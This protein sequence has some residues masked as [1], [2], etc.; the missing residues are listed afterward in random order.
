MADTL[1]QFWQ[2]QLAV[3]QADQKAAQADL[4][5]AQASLQSARA[6]L[7]TDQKALDKAGSD[8]A[9][10]RAQLAVTTVPA[11]ANALVAQITQ[12]IIGQRALQG[13]V[14]DDKDLFADIQASLDAATATLARATSRVT[15]IQA[16]I[17]AAQGDAAKRDIYRSAIVAAPLVTLKGDATAFLASA[18]VTHAKS[19]IGK[20]FPG[21][22]LAIADK[23]HDTRTNR[24]KSLQTDLSNACDALAAEQATDDGLAGA[25]AQ[26]KHAFQRAQDTL[27]NYVAV[28]A[29][30]FVK[31]KAVMAALEA[32]EVAPPNTVSDVLTGPEQAQL[33]ALLP[34]GEA[35]EPTAENL[36]TDLNGVF[37]ADAALKSQILAAI[38]AN[39]DG[40]STDPNINAKRTAVA[41]AQTTF[42]N[43]LAAFAAANKKDLDLWEAVVPDS[44][45][46][47]LVDYQEALAALNDLSA[48][49]PAALAVAMDNAEADY[50]TAL[51]VAAVAQRRQDY[52]GDAI[53]LSQERL[54]AAQGT[55][56]AR[57]LSAVRG[58][59]Y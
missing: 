34:A 7:A 9:A 29:N 31:A 13:T 41:T 3:Y 12:M 21:K 47:V 43:A 26:K 54:D 4:A 48:S 5:T 14:L 22:L 28:A 38:T 57:M 37:N 51:G 58:D 27:A 15:S 49:D 40:L 42:K 8:I 46:K 39:V 6:K 32:I 11:D 30:R 59:S 56:S 35:A 45:W 10:A 53:A 52:F 44:A 19:R 18:T 50:V 36:D 1:P 24:V 55:L 20:N 25:A 33:T 17:A 23:E 16:T 2:Q